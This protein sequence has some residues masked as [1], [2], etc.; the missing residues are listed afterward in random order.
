ML[1]TALQWYELWFK[2]LV[3]DLRAVLQA[4][5]DTFEPIKLV[6][7]G[8][9]L[10]HLFEL[11]TA[12]LETTLV[13]EDKTIKELRAPGRSGLS[14]Q[15][16][17]L[18]GLSRRLARLSRAAPLELAGV[19]D[20][21]LAQFRAFRS[22]FQKLVRATLHPRRAEATTYGEWLHLSE[23]LSLQEGV[24]AAWAEA[25]H[26]PTALFKPEWI[27]PDENMF[28]V[29]HQCFE[30]W[31]RIMLDQI[32]R[33]IQLISK[34]DIAEATR[35]VRRTAQVQHVLNVQIQIP[36][37]MHAA[38]FMLFREQTCER[39]GKVLR[40]GL[41][42]ASG[43]ES[44]Q[45]REIEIAC[46]LGRDPVFAKYL[47]GSDKLPIR[48]LTPRQAERLKQPSLAAAFHSAVERRSISDLK[49][50]FTP[51]R[52]HNPNAD[53]ADLADALVE[54]DE[55]FRM[56]RINH[57]SMVEKMI[58]GKSGTGFLGPE[59]LMETA[60]LKPRE[61][62]R[63]FEEIQARPRFFE[64]LWAVRSRLASN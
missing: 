44:Y 54:L 29:V 24:K 47:A 60:G 35:L 43:T 17:E 45:F 41:S 34:D 8:L 5:K 53:L 4:S 13:R 12:F 33:A 21:Y 15:M 23:L 58:G 38:D 31:F 14:H 11:Q 36:A 59:Y 61:K 25:G 40:T 27:S 50:L 6:R 64:D 52:V 32:D 28:V 10:F 56:W 20:E 30:L 18:A 49:D 62:N 22:R 48:L 9:A 63:I 1:L 57:V 3:T 19:A 39:E 7:R 46:G 16:A 26:Q 2:V 55:A 51:A 37:T 42:P